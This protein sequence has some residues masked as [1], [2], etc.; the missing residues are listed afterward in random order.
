MKAVTSRTKDLDDI[1]IIIQKN[2]VNWYI[3]VN[4]AENQVNLGNELAVISMG[5]KFEDLN[6]KN[7]AIIPKPVLDKLWGLLNKQVKKKKEKKKRQGKN[8]VKKKKHRPIVKGI[9]NN[10]KLYIFPLTS[11]IP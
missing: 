8:N 1:A 10:P 5:E 2:R 4:E 3:V 11:R 7:I 6:N 9:I